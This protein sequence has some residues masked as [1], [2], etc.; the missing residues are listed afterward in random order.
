MI[1]YKNLIVLPTYHGSLD[2]V[3]ELRKLF[4]QNPP[5]VIAVEF[6]ENLRQK[7][8]AG[9]SR[10]PKISVVLYYDQLIKNQLYVP[11]IPSDSLIEALRLAEE[12]GI[13]TEFIDLFV[14]D[15]KPKPIA[16]PDSHLLNY[17]SLDT[18]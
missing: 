18:F 6:P 11:I 8:V 17:L 1:R 7:I 13:I 4:Y 16:M 12:Y 5:D 14:N 2:F 3:F 9:V 15:Y 10:L